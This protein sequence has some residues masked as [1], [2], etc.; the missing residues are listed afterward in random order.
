MNGSRGDNINALGRK[1]GAGSLSFAH[2]LGRALGT[3]LRLLT[4]FP[5]PS[6]RDPY[7]ISLAPAWEGTGV[8]KVRQPSSEFDSAPHLSLSV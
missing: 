5:D 1:V 8:V 4:F 3:M 7:P 2:P 6:L